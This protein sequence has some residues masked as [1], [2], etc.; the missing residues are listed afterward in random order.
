ME[1]IGIGGSVMEDF[2]PVRRLRD[3]LAESLLAYRPPFL[4]S[5]IDVDEARNTG[6]LVLTWGGHYL[7]ASIC[8][9]QVQPETGS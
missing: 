1:Q 9:A 6:L 2:C 8:R 3:S 5:P 7:P 4:I